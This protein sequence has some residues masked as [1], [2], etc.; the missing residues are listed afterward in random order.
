MSSLFFA[1]TSKYVKSK[2]VLLIAHKR[3]DRRKCR[4]FARSVINHSN[5]KQWITND[6]PNLLSPSLTTNNP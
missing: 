4:S 1:R 5:N 6:R 2:M 3:K